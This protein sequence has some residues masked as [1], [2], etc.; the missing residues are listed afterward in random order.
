MRTLVKCKLYSPRFKGHAELSAAEG[1]KPEG[2]PIV[3]ILKKSSTALVKT[4]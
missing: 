4:G 2:G 1:P 3:N